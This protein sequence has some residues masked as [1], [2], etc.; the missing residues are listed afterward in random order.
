MIPT[1]Y[2]LFDFMDFDPSLRREEA[3]W[4]AYAPSHVEE[5]DGDILITIPYQRQRQ[6]PDMAADER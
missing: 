3:L 6:Q 4:K 1:N 5:R 2:H